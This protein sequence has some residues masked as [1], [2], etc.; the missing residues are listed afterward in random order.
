MAEDCLKLV[1]EDLLQNM[2]N[3]LKRKSFTMGFFR[4]IF[5][6]SCFFRASR[7]NYKQSKAIVLSETLDEAT[8]KFLE[9]DK[10]P[11]RKVG[12]L[13]NRGSSFLFG[14]VLG[15]RIGYTK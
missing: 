13:D 1:Q 11:S 14:N 8:D 4:R 6:I 5:G 2:C 7:K 12:E 9:N 3:N 10:S 15:T